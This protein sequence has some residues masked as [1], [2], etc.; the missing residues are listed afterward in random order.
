VNDDTGSSRQRREHVRRLLQVP[1]SLCT[2][3]EPL[4][5]KAHLIDIGRGGVALVTERTLEVGD[6]VE[7]S[8]HLPGCGANTVI[9]AR[10]IYVAPIPREGFFRI[11]ARF[12]SLPQEVADAI[13]EFVTSPVRLGIAD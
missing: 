10:V 8:F 2:M 1:A 12:E 3:T 9:S 13:V 4:I 11:G 5:R 7:L 6:Q